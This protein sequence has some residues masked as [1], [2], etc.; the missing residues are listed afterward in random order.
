M[1]LR[2]RLLGLCSAGVG[3]VRRAHVAFAVRG[4]SYV[5]YD[6]NIV[7]DAGVEALIKA[8]AVRPLHTLAWLSFVV[9]VLLFTGSRE[10]LLLPQP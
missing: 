3:S 10:A 5:D 7:H 2:S 8:L 9:S 4:V 6:S 1:A